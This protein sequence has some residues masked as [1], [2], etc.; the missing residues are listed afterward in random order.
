MKND[1]WKR[2]VKKFIDILCIICT[3]TGI[4]GLTIIGYINEK[5]D[6]KKIISDM[7]ENFS[8]LEIAFWEKVKIN[9]GESIDYSA[10]KE[11]DNNI[12]INFK[13]APVLGKNDEGVYVPVYYVSLELEDN[14]NCCLKNSEYEYSGKLIDNELCFENIV[15]GQY[16]IYF[17]NMEYNCFAYENLVYGYQDIFYN[18]SEFH[19]D[20]KE[21]TEEDVVIY[22]IKGQ[23]EYSKF[24]I[25]D[26]RYRNIEFDFRDRNSKYD[27]RIK[28]IFSTDDDGK[29]YFLVDWEYEY[30]SLHIHE[31][32]KNT[33]ISIDIEK[34]NNGKEYI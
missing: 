32:Y 13:Y 30:I 3:I 18:E 19:I 27:G 16:Q 7:K 11:Y 2:N 1:S 22:L 15:P 34:E 29:F 21:T 4:T 20:I 31:K 6:G 14:I 9:D 25:S 28:G 23:E 33:H 12:S 10:E 24:E 26:K 8:K 17:E 5:I